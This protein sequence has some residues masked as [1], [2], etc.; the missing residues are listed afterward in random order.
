MLFREENKTKSLQ[1][2]LEEMKID[3]ENNEQSKIM[4][5]RQLEQVRE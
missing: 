2:R 1:L 5:S 4:L 3:K